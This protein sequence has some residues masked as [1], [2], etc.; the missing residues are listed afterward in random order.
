M[1]GSGCGLTS[2]S[3]S[4]PSS[5]SVRNI[6]SSDSRAAS[7]APIQS[8]PGATSLQHLAARAQPERH[9]G[10]H[11]EE[12]QERIQRF[13]AVADRQDQVA[14]HDGGERAHGFVSI[15]TTLGTTPASA[16]G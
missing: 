14:A 13:R 9:E 8:T 15:R 7:S 5:K 6:R 2:M 11:D 1:I 10:D 16:T 3:S 12:E 4:E